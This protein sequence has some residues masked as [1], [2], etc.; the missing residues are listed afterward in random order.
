MGQRRVKFGQGQGHLRQSIGIGAA[1]RIQTDNAGLKRFV[2]AAKGVAREL[3]QPGACGQHHLALD[4]QI[5]GGGA[6]QIFGRNPH[7]RHI[8]Q[9]HG[10]GQ[11]QDKVDPFGQEI[12]DQ[13]LRAG[14]RYIIDIGI[15]ID[16][17]S[18][19]RG[20]ACGG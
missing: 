17:P 3:L 16:S 10:F 7:H 19:T 5:G 14:Q 12:L 20:G 13:N 2:I 15:N 1:A 4:R 8:G 18:P 11:G 9:R 6:E